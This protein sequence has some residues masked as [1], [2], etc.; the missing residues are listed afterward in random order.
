MISLFCLLGYKVITVLINAHKCYIS[1]P[2]NKSIVC[3]IH[4]LYYILKKIVVLCITLPCRRGSRPDGARITIA[5]TTATITI[6]GLSFITP[7]LG[8]ISLNWSLWRSEYED[9][10]TLHMCGQ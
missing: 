7:F 9:F 6:I 10:V 8:L 2:C 5:V 1:I 3:F 4:K